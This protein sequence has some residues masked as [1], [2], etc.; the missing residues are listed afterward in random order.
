MISI[1]AGSLGSIVC[2]QSLLGDSVESEWEEKY[3][4]PPDLAGLLTVLL[5]QWISW[6]IVNTC[7]RWWHTTVACYAPRHSLSH[8]TDS[9]RLSPLPPELPYSCL[10]P[11]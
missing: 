5:R 4:S 11:G 1:C 9:P 3:A 8:L 2:R 7:S 10:S 6:G